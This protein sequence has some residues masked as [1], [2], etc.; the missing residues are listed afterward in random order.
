MAE[1]DTAQIVRYAMSAD[2]SKDQLI[3]DVVDL[4]FEVDR[5]RNVVIKAARQK[6]IETVVTTMLNSKQVNGGM[7][8]K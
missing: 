1:I 8:P 3:T 5:L 7:F 4:C 2:P 6:L